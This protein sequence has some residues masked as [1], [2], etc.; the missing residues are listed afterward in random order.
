MVTLRG[1]VIVDDHETHHE[2]R[3]ERGTLT[4]APLPPH[5]ESEVIEGWVL[6]GLVDAHCHIGFSAEGTAGEATMREQ[7]HLTAQTGVLLTRDAGM[8]IDTRV[9]DGDPR[10]PRIIRAGQHI[11]RP[12]RYVR[13]LPLNLEDPEELPLAL[14]EQALAG[15]GWVKLVGDWID[16]SAGIDADL[17]PLWSPEQLQQGI[18]AAHA[19]GARV[20]V[21]T[22][23][24]ATIDPLLAAGVDCIEHGCGMSREQMER[25]AAAGIAVTPTLSQVE[26]FIEIAEQAGEKFPVYG[27]HMRALYENRFSQV[28][29]MYDAGL[30]LLVGSDS[31]GGV[32]HGRYHDEIDLLVRAGIPAGAIVGAASYHA[33]RY[34]GVPGISEG[35]PA[36]VVVYGADPR[37]DA[38]VL[39]EPL[40]I[41]RDG[42]RI[43]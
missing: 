34:F 25:A 20:M 24:H 39:R 4:F 29:Q 31:G 37:E 38:R 40:A 30:L 6:P 9:L 18:A 33:R 8:P 36:D 5:L 32:A 13:E 42:E 22:F 23:A 12:K 43:R 28:R 3:I 14:A 41:F 27:A 11:A 2:V 26:N 15:D 10:S 17:Q 7:A 1:T 21:H 19:N 16:R 35:A